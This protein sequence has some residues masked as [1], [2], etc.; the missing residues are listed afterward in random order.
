LELKTVPASTIYPAIAQ[1][2]LRVLEHNELAYITVADADSLTFDL[3]VQSNPSDAVVSYKRHGDD[4]KDA[5]EKTKTTLKSLPYAIWVVRVQ[6]P[7]LR[8][9]ELEHDP[10]TEQNHVLH[11]ELK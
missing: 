2:T 4:F 8:A 6:A 3:E 9:K 1:G 11:F 10:F 7:G 5:P